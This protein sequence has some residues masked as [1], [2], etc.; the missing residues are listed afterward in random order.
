MQVVSSVAA[1]QRLAGKWRRAGIKV[2]FVPTMGYLHAGHLSLVKRARKFA[3]RSG[4]VVVS[5][6]VNPTQFG[7]KE[8]LS[9]YPRDLK[10]DLKLCREEGADV[11]FTPH[12]QDIYPD[13]KQGLY[14]TYVVEEK[15]SLGMEG[16]SRPG[17]FRGVATVVAKLFNIVQPDVAV[18][19][20]KDF[21]QAAV[22]KR[23]VRDLNFPVKIDVAPTFREPDGLAM[24]S[25]N[26]YLEGDLRRQGVVLSRAIRKAQV[27]VKKSSVSAT[28]LREDLKKLIESE[29]DARLDYVEFFDPDTLAPVTKVL[30]GTQM[31]LAV[32]V[33]K[34]RLI[35]NARL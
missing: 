32:F 11:V 26:K 13:K 15:L 7:P 22:I 24:S 14:T 1:M 19:G 31:A 23:M 21:Q 12:D 27:A 3:G 33:G 28:R 34:A 8:D 20:A 6:Y 5:I 16:A 29:P 18:F 25:R 30:R 2:G 17:H 10:R 4:R 9:R 35:D